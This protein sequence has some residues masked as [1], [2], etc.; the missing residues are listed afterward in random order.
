MKRILFLPVGDRDNPSS[1]LI[2]Y[3][4]AKYLKRLGWPVAVGGN[5]DEFDIIIFQK[6]LDAPDYLLAKKL[7]GRKKI[8]FQLSEA[9]HLHPNWANRVG[10]FAK[11]AD[12][13]VAGTPMIQ[14][15]FRNSST[16]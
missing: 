9:Y 12:V 4:N 3:E 13:S 10:R 14:N 15:Y 1:R 5:P 7:K 8:V 2:C 11:L 16:E 6:R